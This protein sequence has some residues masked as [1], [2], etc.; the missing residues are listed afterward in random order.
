MD[1]GAGLRWSG[2]RDKDST[3]LSQ[4]VTLW[5]RCHSSSPHWWWRHPGWRHWCSRWYSAGRTWNTEPEE[6][7]GRTMMARLQNLSRDPAPTSWLFE[8]WCQTAVQ[9]DPEIWGKDPPTSSDGPERQQPQPIRR[10]VSDYWGLLIS[11]MNTDKYW[12]LTTCCMSGCVGLNRRLI[13][14]CS[15][16]KVSFLRMWRERR[17][18]NGPRWR[19]DSPLSS[20]QTHTHTNT[21]RIIHVC[22]KS[23]TFSDKCEGE[24]NSC[25]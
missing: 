4:C 5:R 23:V 8:E 11:L 10:E 21:H 6:L 16:T 15:G 22:W 25:F 12:W 18:F 3:S 24:K 7:P 19:R 1:E 14:T 17:S 2:G 9:V 20:E 13:S